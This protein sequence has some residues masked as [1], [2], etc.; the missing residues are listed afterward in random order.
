MA[1]TATARSEPDRYGRI[2]APLHT[3]LVLAAQGAL[4]VRGVIRA[5][6]ARAIRNV[7]VDR[8]SGSSWR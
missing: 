3:I 2:A 8:S 4:V 6:Q 1:T 7:G 5:D